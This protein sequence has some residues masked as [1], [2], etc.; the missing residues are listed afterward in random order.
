MIS[1]E[2]RNRFLTSILLLI[3]TFLL[4]KS[5]IVLIC[6]LLILGIFSLIEFFSLTKK[7][8]KKNLLY[9]IVNISFTIYM[10]LYCYFFI[11]FSLIIQFKIIIFILLFGCIAS[12]LGGYIF[13][14]IFKGPKL[15]KISPNKTIS[16]S[17]GSFIF[18]Y[19]FILIPI[20]F[21]TNKINFEIL[22]ISLITSLGCQIGD[23]FFSFLK[24]T[25]K[26]KDT[27]NYLPGHGGFLDRLD[28]I[29]L[30]LPMGIITLF[31]LHI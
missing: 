10:F 30:G 7:I 5:N 16:G 6:S 23:L 2:F 29:L 13:G 28:G 15:T 11:Y 17:I 22:I 24:R 31:L 26:V 21:I 3:L 9:F 19:C 25:A 4:I 18:T 12:D 27:S 1:T 20:F 14:K 8:F